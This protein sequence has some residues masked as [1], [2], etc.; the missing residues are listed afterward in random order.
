MNRTHRLRLAVLVGGWIACVYLLF[1]VQHHPVVLDYM[2]IWQATWL[3]DTSR[4][5]WQGVSDRVTWISLGI[6]AA[7]LVAGELRRRNLH[8][9]RLFFL[10]AGLAVAL[11]GLVNY[12]IKIIARA[13]RPFRLDERI[14]KWSSGGSFSFPSGHTAEAFA[15]ATIIWFLFPRLYVGIPLLIWATAVGWSRILLGVHTPADVVAGM[16][17]GICSSYLFYSLLPKKPT[18]ARL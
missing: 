8:N 15:A 7:V 13:P 12:L 10:Q 2:V 14:V 18:F 4:H 9:T 16:L 1:T 11:A 3:T 6:P 17:T 5:L